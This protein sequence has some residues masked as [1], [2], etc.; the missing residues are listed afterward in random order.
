MDALLGA[1]L[2]GLSRC[3]FRDVERSVKDASELANGLRTG[4]GPALA[5]HCPVRSPT[6]PAEH[7]F[8][9]S[10]YSSARQSPCPDLAPL[11]R[12]FPRLRLA[13]LRDLRR[14]YLRRLLHSDHTFSRVSCNQ[15]TAR[16]CK[17][18]ESACFVSSWRTGGWHMEH[19]AGREYRLRGGRGGCLK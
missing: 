14:A 10:C 8:L 13:A 15:R 3:G 11:C 2:C 19:G 17:T 18:S 6:S 7:L 12:A 5:R 16:A 1:R 9:S 4:E